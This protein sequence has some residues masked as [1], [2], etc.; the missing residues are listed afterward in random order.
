LRSLEKKRRKE[1]KKKKQAKRK[2]SI[3]VRIRRANER[4]Q[5]PTANRIAVDSERFSNIVKYQGKVK[6][7]AWQR[8]GIN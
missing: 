2:A 4:T 5:F 8:A 3:R 1:G 6:W 7:R